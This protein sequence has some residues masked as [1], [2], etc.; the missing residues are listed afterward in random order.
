MILSMA[1]AM[2]EEGVSSVHVPAICK[3]I[4]AEISRLEKVAIDQLSN[5][6][7]GEA[8]KENEQ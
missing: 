8:L 4:Q 6:L 5:E 2:F 7:T 3:A 1:R